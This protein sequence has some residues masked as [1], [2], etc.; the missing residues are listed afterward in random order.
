MKITAALVT[1]AT[2]AVSPVSA[3]FT[4][5]ISAAT[6]PIQ[7]DGTNYTITPS[8]KCHGKQYCLTASGTLPTEIIEGSSYYI[9]RF[10]LGRLAYTDRKDLALFSLPVV[11]LASFLPVHST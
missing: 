7:Y 2:A 9:E 4:N 10:Y 6:S 11:H 5:F 1:L 8:P 3:Q